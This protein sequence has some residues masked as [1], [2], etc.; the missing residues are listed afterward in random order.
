MSE[1]PGRR[2]EPFIFAVLKGVGALPAEY[3]T[4]DWRADQRGRFKGLSGAAEAICGLAVAG[5]AIAAILHL[6]GG[7]WIEIPM[8]VLCVAFAVLMKQNLRHRRERRTIDDQT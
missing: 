2:S 8:F 4:E 1:S 3:T 6:A 7:L 5:L